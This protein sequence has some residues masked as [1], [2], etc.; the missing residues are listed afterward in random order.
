MSCF[1]STIKSIHSKLVN[2]EFSIDITD[3]VDDEN[4]NYKKE[5][6]DD[7]LFA[8]FNKISFNPNFIINVIWAGKQSIYSSFIKA[9][10]TRPPRL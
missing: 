6:G 3:T 8:E 1:Q 2:I 4:E 9:I 7:D 10:P 5:L